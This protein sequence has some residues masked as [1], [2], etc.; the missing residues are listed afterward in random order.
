M[1]LV[2]V[3]EGVEDEATFDALRAL[4][5]DTMQG[6]WISRPLGIIDAEQW[7]R[8]SARAQSDF[9]ASALGHVR[10]AVS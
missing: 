4:G 6:Y 5:C 2:V 8:E 1:G 10:Q 3:A 9:E 7:L